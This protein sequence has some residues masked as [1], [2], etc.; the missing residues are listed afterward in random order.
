MTPEKG[1]GVEFAIRQLFP[2]VAASL[3]DSGI[4]GEPGEIREKTEKILSGHKRSSF[5]ASDMSRFYP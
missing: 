1:V 5:F 2:A 4:A 3:D